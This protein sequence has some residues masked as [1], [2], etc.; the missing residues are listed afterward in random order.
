MN[1]TIKKFTADLVADFTKKLASTGAAS[2]IERIKADD[3]AI[4]FKVIISTADE[5]RQGD[6][7]DQ[8]KWNLDNFKNNPVVL[9]AH[10]YCNPPI[11]I[12][13][14]ISVENGKLVAEGKFAPAEL[15]PLAG[16]IA[17]LYEAGYINATSV[18]YFVHENGEMELLEFSFVPVPA[19]PFALSMREA[20]QLNLNIPQLVMKGISFATKGA[21]PYHD[22][23]KAEEDTPW[24]GPNE[25][26]ECGDDFDKLKAICAW[27]DA[28]N[29][30]VKSSYKLPHH[31]ASDRK[32]VWNGVKA[33]MGALLGAR[34]GAK[35]DDKEAV[36]NHLK[37][38]YAAFDK[39]APEFE[40]AMEIGAYLEAGKIEKAQA[41]ATILDFDFLISKSPQL[42][43]R[44]ELDDGTPG[45]L[46][47]DEKNPGELVC[48][49]ERDKSQE[50]PADMNNELLKNLKA[51]HERHG[52]AVAKHID[53]F[54]E[55]AEELKPDEHDKAIEE[56]RTKL[57][58]EHDE[59]MAACMKAIDESYEDMGREDG[60]KKAQ[61]KSIEEFKE[62][63]QGEHL[64]HVKAFHKA[65]D[66][67]KKDFSDGDGE[68]ERTKA[69]EEFTKKAGAEL[70]RHEKAQMDMMEDM[71]EGE[72]DNKGGKKGIVADIFMQNAEEREKDE[73]MNYVMTVMYAFCNAYYAA[74]VDAFYGLIAEAIQLIQ[75]YVK[76]EAK[77][78]DEEEL[79]EGQEQKGIVAKYIA[80]GKTKAGRAI[81]AKNKEKLK[82][83]VKGMQD[84][85][86]EHGKST[87]EVIAALKELIG[88]EES[89]EGKE[90]QPTKGGAPNSRSRTSGVATGKASSD[91]DAYLLSQRLVRQIK[92]SAEEGLRQI[93]TALKKR[94]PSRRF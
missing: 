22:Y 94:Y 91:L 57:D 28:E 29:P 87:D 44:C 7:L 1:E 33:A 93:N 34:G 65:I 5:D 3:K 83:I 82:A 80:E 39:D 21:V 92:T 11:G 55:K 52:E 48:V 78:S 72:G 51:E 45:I 60:N 38:H 86:E 71:G 74:P 14:G 2:F 58:G 81:S 40:K 26:K 19:N 31:R 36:Y 15:N 35:I 18:G 42:G 49:P 24:D 16:Q 53:E 12:C 32:A 61:K 25:V 27:Y 10:D 17:G 77:E 66:E 84:H 56:F 89:D 9:W 64:E 67:F 6:A 59:H 69:I 76:N 20:K 62:M 43:D 30:D 75:D 63:M 79:A 85:H 90:H 68:P 13:T 88:S 23:G 37:K 50:D 70:E 8:S 47:E 4:P 41:L 46:A 73:R 54:T